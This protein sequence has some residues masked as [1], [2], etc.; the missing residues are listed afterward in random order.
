M[1]SNGWKKIGVIDT[2]GGARG[3]AA[4]GLEVFPA[5]TVEEAAALLHRLAEED[6]AVV[7][8]AEHLAQGMEA[9]L[10]RYQDRPSPAVILIPG[11][12]GS[13]GLGMRALKNAVERAVG[14]DILNT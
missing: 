10:D 13:R 3:F 12:G 2:G 6:Y 1:S 9:E 8:L 14:A 5:E 4:L 7:D 11:S